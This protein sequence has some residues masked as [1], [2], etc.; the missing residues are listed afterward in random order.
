MDLLEAGSENRD[1]L[2]SPIKHV[3]RVGLCNNLRLGPI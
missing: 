2:F 1:D 3:Y